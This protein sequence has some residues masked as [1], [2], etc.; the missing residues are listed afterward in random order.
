MLHNHINTLSTLGSQV[1]ALT[2][3]LFAGGVMN[4]L[5]IVV[6]AL[7]IFLKKVIP[8]GCLI[9]RLVG[10][11]LIAGSVWMFSMGTS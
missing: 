5:W 9:A 11:A 6:L 7:L 4:V 10:I 8:L 2:A 3:L 1:W